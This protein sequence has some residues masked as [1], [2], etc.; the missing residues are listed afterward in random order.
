MET[1]EDGL[2]NIDLE[3]WLKDHDG[4]PENGLPKIIDSKTERDESNVLKIN[5]YRS[6]DGLWKL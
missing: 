2:Q 4:S 6:E 3:K 1:F 5:S